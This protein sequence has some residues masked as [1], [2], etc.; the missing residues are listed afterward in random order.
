MKPSPPTLL[1]WSLFVCLD[2]LEHVLP[3][4]VWP[5]WQL[6]FSHTAPPRL[7][8][9]ADGHLTKLNDFTKCLKRSRR[10]LHV[11]TDRN[12]SSCSELKSEKLR[13]TLAKWEFEICLN[14]MCLWC[15]VFHNCVKHKTHQTKL[16]FGRC[17]SILTLMGEQFRSFYMKLKLKVNGNWNL[18]SDIDS[19]VL[20]KSG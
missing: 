10:R 3:V 7:F 5:E 14:K 19:Y 17:F 15:V 4:C 12:K 16:V 6:C 8:S 13:G 9:V 20:N 11:W 18:S 1:P 2:S